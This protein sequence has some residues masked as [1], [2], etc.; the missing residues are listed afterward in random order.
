MYVEIQQLEQVVLDGGDSVAAYV[1]NTISTTARPH[2]ISYKETFERQF[3]YRSLRVFGSECYTRVAKAK[4]SKL[5]IGG[6]RC[7]MLD[8]IAN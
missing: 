6:V 7:N 3:T 8:N 4:R 1:R 5:D 2:T